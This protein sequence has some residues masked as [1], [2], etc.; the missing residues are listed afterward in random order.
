MGQYMND[1][2]WT[3]HVAYT[4]ATFFFHIYKKLH[5]SNHKLDVYK[6]NICSGKTH[7]SNIL[8]HQRPTS[9]RKQQ[10]WL[11]HHRIQLWTRASPL[12]AQAGLTKNTMVMQ[13]N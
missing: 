8:Y 9:G 5:I 7:K 2:L 3:H 1:R 4:E 6:H 11:L 10:F 13:P 12:R